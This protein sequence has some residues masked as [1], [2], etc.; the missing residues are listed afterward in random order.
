M[1]DRNTRD[2]RWLVV[3]DLPPRQAEI[4]RN[5]L[6]DCLAGVRGDL[7]AP[8]GMPNSERARTEADAYERLLTAL[9]RGQVALPDE[10]AREALA[11]IAA[12]ADR[13]NEYP[14]VLAEH[15]ALHGLL[16][17]LTAPREA[18]P[19]RPLTVA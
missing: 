11:A 17:R 7:E 5:T 19:R 13:E 9:D 18:P 1:A 12:S 14:R 4:L 3:L 15:D 6:G 16:A 10:P 2:N 8:A